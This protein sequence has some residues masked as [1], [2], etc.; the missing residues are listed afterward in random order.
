ISCPLHYT[1]APTAYA[2]AQVGDKQSVDLWLM[3]SQINWINPGRP[4]PW[5]VADSGF[6]ALA[7]QKAATLQ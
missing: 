2:A 5:T 4:Y 6:R 7:A 3:N 1:E